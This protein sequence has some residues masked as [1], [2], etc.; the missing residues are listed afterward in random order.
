MVSLR[1]WEHCVG[2]TISVEEF[3]QMLLYSE[4][5]YMDLIWDNKAEEKEGPEDQE[6]KPFEVE[7]AQ[8]REGDHG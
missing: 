4:D 5:E 1:G 8:M 3:E 2:T 7:D 6:P